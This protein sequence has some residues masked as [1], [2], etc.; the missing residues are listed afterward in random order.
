MSGKKQ[1]KDQVI[2]LDQ[3]KQKAQGQV[4]DIPDWEPD[5]TIKVRVRKIDI[6]PLLLSSGTIPN[7]L[8]NEVSNYLSEGGDPEKAVKK[9]AK[10]PPKFDSTKFLPTL[11]AIVKEALVEPAYEELEKVYPLNMSQK[12][13][14]FKYVTGGIEDMKSFRD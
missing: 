2:T 1:N 7:E 13:A 8:S 14:I 5:K 3:V 11:N 12:L 10:N 6:T 4:I 9:M